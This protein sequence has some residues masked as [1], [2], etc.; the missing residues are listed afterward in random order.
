MTKSIVFFDGV[1]NLCN[2]SVQLIIKKDKRQTFQFAS[3]QSEFAKKKLPAS[4]INESELK[5]IVLMKGDQFFTKSTAAL[6]IAKMLSGLW[7]ILYIFIIIPKILRDF[8]YDIIATNRYN[9]FGKKDQ[10]IIPSK[11]LKSR[12]LD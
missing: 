4:L 8:I 10:C 9:W 7:P 12:F 6:T 1:C 11:Q 5:S 2:S 3:L